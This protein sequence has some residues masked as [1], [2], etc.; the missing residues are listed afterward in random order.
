M[1]LRP[2]QPGRGF[3]VG[4]LEALT[5]VMGMAQ[6]YLQDHGRRAGHLARLVG[7]RMGLSQEKIAELLFA[8]VLADVGMIGLVE[9]AWENP[10][11]TLKPEVR[12]RV[13]LHPIRSEA[14]VLGIPHLTAVAPV[15]RHHHEWWNGAGYPDGLSGA[16]IPVASSILRLADTVAALGEIRPQ[17]PARPFAEIRRVVREGS[18]VEFSPAAAEAFLAL[19]AEGAPPEPD[20]GDFHRSLFKAAERLFPAEISPLSV[21]QLLEILAS[22]IDAKDPYTA[23]HSRRVAILAVAMATRLGLDDR[24]KETVWAAGYLHDVGKLSVPLRVLTKE[25]PLDEDERIAVAL[26]TH[27]GAGILAAIPSL[28]HLTPGIRYHHERWD[29]GGYPEGLSGDHIPLVAQILAVCDAYDAMTSGRAYQASRSH[30]EAVEEIARATGQHFGPG[31]AAWFLSLP[32]PLFEAVRR[33][34]HPRPGWLGAPSTHP[35]LRRGGWTGAA[36]A[37]RFA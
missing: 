9:D 37:A 28:R 34:R 16:D 2:I 11:T 4:L 12:A 19:T 36:S 23:G 32:E 27:V 1:N 18:G 8:S 22:L 10:V 17:R 29:G 20:P 3:Y 14:A 15:V 6:G 7:E 21:E 35:P 31:V 25:G 5:R 26:H 30:L 33:A 13:R 24:M